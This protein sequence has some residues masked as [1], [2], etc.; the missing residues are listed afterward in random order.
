MV[1]FRFDGGS[2]T[3]QLARTEIA[4]G[5]PV[6]AEYAAKLVYNNITTL[7]NVVCMYICRY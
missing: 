4:P 3:V 6:F 7:G 5:A 1:Y 2:V